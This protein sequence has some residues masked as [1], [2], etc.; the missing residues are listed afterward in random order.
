MS[1]V[2]KII[3]HPVSGFIHPFGTPTS[4]M[5]ESGIVSVD[6]GDSI[7]FSILTATDGEIQDVVID[8]ASIG[9]VNSYTFNNVSSDHSITAY[10]SY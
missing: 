3:T 2:Y 8:G 9:A 4:L 10:I 5:S 1:N 7:T 6:E